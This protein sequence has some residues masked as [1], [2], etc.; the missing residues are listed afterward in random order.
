MAQIF[1]DEEKFTVEDGASFNAQAES[2][3]I[4]FGCTE[5]ICGSC[6]VE[7]K[8]GEDNLNDLTQEEIDMGMSKTERLA[9]QCKIK[10]GIVK[11][12]YW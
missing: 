11:F 3:G 6:R 9:C 4:P 2:A 8:E 5:G 7:V 10:S 12:T 1:I